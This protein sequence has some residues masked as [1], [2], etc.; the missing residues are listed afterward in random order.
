[1]QSYWVKINWTFFLFSPPCFITFNSSAFNHHRCC[2]IEIRTTS[3]YFGTRV[4]RSYIVIAPKGLVT[5]RIWHFQLSHFDGDS[6]R[7]FAQLRMNFLEFPYYHLVTI[8]LQAQ[9]HAANYCGYR[10]PDDAFL[11]YS[12]DVLVSVNTDALAQDECIG[13][14]YT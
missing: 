1:M 6:F 10:T 11:I 2:L 3:C 5:I 13:L 7:R 9:I 8:L 14:R 4:D 12:R